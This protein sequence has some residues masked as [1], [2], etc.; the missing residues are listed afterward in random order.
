MYVWTY[1]RRLKMFKWNCTFTLYANFVCVCVRVCV[2]ANWV[3][4]R[5]FAK[6]SSFCRHTRFGNTH[7]R[8]RSYDMNDSLEHPTSMKIGL[9]SRNARCVDELRRPSERLFGISIDVAKV[10]IKRQTPRFRRKWCGIILRNLRAYSYIQHILIVL[11]S[12][13][14]EISTPDVL[15]LFG[16]V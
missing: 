16:R 2:S 11:V 12:M 14:R 10:G 6:R 9:C 7:T 5:A 8:R 3:G 4:D 13:R 15:Y 1:A